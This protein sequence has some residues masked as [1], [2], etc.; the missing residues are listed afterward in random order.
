MQRQPC[1]TLA[2]VDGHIAVAC[3]WSFRNSADTRPA[4]HRGAAP[5]AWWQRGARTGV[6]ST[7]AST[8]A[9]CAWS[10]TSPCALARP[11]R[12]TV[13]LSD[14]EWHWGCD[15]SVGVHR[16]GWLTPYTERT[17]G[18]DYFSLVS[19]LHCA[20]AMQRSSTFRLGAEAGRFSRHDNNDNADDGCNEEHSD[21][22]WLFARPSCHPRSPLS[23]SNVSPL[24]TRPLP[25]TSP[26]RCLCLS[27]LRLLLHDAHR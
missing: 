19:H 1:A 22:G 10:C 7:G 6:D 3:V 5:S 12:T 14:R 26:T 13:C 4:R 27:F 24:T 21:H 9:A 18:T 2:S 17:D 25:C 8:L 20:L 11:P 23:F 16:F 15:E